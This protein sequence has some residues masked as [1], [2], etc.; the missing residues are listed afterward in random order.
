MA[1]YRVRETFFRPD[2]PVARATSALP[3]DIFNGLQILL[4]RDDS[5]TVFLP[6]RSMQFQAVVEPEEIVF[7]DANGGYGQRN[8]QGGRLVQ[9]AWRPK[10]GPRD[11]LD[12]PV[13]CEILFYFPSLETVQ[14]RLVGET[15]AALKLALARRR[16]R[17]CGAD[18]ARVLPFSRP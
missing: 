4:S 3:A 6:I 12:A 15:R 17:A 7:V 18:R 2:V 1:S 10:P 14:R 9:I 11:A 16:E 13:P 5:E 8:G